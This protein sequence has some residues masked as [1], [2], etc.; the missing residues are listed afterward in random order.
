MKRIDVQ[1]GVVGD[2]PINI[3]EFARELIGNEYD[4]KEGNGYHSVDDNELLL[5]DSCTIAKTRVSEI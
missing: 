2:T 5:S 1:S 3:V 4:H